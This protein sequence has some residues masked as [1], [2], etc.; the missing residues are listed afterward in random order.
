MDPSD[1]GALREICRKLLLFAGNCRV[2]KKFTHTYLDPLVAPQPAEGG[3]T[4]ALRLPL[5]DFR[6]LP[7]RHLQRVTK[8][9]ADFRRKYLIP[10]LS[11]LIRAL[12]LK[13]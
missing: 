11:A 1:T 12:F 4:S 5:S 8:P 3:W 6:P 13:N 2:K 9:R 7:W 10:R